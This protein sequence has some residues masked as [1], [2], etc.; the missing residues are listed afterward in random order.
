M[1]SNGGLSV[2]EGRTIGHLLQNHHFLILLNMAASEGL[3]LSAS[4]SLSLG[5]SLSSLGILKSEGIQWEY[6]YYTLGCP[7]FMTDELNKFK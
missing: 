6:K 4:H 3:L 2:G 1:G 5:A 7:V